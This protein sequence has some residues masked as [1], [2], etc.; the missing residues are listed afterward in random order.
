MRKISNN[1]VRRIHI[2]VLPYIIDSMVVTYFNASC[3]I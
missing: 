1:V 2:W 3:W